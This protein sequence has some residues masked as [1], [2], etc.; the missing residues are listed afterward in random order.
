MKWQTGMWCSAMLALSGCVNA[1]GTHQ[2]V[3]QA[4]PKSDASKIV[5]Y[6]TEP[7]DAVEIANV[8]ARST[9]FRSEAEKMEIA[10]DRLKDEAAEVGA[11]GIV[12]DVSDDA[13]V[14]KKPGIV[15]TPDRLSDFVKNRDHDV[16]VS[17]T[18]IWVPAAS[19]KP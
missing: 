1:L 10:L 4:R 11:N 6:A 3:G 8:A 9:V 18:A 16:M 7:A 13:V 5:F 12:L 14:G 2:L 17:G 19:E 15:I